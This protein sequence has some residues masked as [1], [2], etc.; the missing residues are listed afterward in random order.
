MKTTL[1]MIF[2][3][4]LFTSSF[5]I[6]TVNTNRNDKKDTI[7][8]NFFHQGFDPSKLS[9]PQILNMDKHQYYELTG[10]KMNFKERVGLKIFQHKLNK[11]VRKNPDL[12]L[13][14]FLKIYE[15]KDPTVTAILVLIILTAVIGIIILLA[16]LGNLK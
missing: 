1:L 11:E 15:D 10:R 8:K 4:V 16:N 5:A 7:E 3:F 9:V 14:E 13:Q 2:S 6:T 12:D